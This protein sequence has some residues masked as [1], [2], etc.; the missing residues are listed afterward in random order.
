[1][2][3]GWVRLLKDW[4]PA[5]KPRFSIGKWEWPVYSASKRRQR[6][7]GIME[8]RDA[9]FQEAKRLPRDF[10]Q[11]LSDF[12]SA[13]NAVTEQ[14]WYDFC[15]KWSAKLSRDPDLLSGLVMDCGL[16]GR[17][18]RLKSDEKS[19]HSISYGP[20]EPLDTIIREAAFKLA[21]ENRKWLDSIINAFKDI[22]VK[23]PE[24][25]GPSGE[26]APTPKSGAGPALTGDAKVE[27]LQ[28]IKRF[29]ENKLTEIAE[30]HESVVE[31]GE[32][33]QKDFRSV[34]LTESLPWTFRWNRT[35]DKFRLAVEFLLSVLKVAGRSPEGFEW[36]EL[37]AQA[38]QAIGG[39]KMFDR[40][41]EKLLDLIQEICGMPLED[42]GLTS[43]GSLYPVYILGKIELTFCAESQNRCIGQE[44]DLP[45]ENPSNGQFRTLSL[46]SLHAITNFE[47]EELKSLST[48]AGRIILTENR[49]LLIKMYKTGWFKKSPE[50]F[51]VGIDGRLR[52]SHHR[53][54]KLLQRAAPHIPC[55]IW[56]DS[57][58]PGISF[59]EELH[60][61]FPGARVVFIEGHNLSCLDYEKFTEK[62]KA[63]PDLLNRE[64][65]SLL[66]GPDDWD[67]VFQIY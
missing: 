14:G 25:Y 57:D 23:T 48:P 3:P 8:F 9:S 40:D 29:L 62:I 50:S 43:R 30:L 38:Q 51:V 11:A 20:M 27:A 56:T 58:S 34:R 17:F 63:R 22:E 5:E 41:R 12:F 36:K 60:H 10:L 59:V 66:G 45:Q 39:S 53:I 13:G 26:S 67:R 19:I 47:V 15:K 37:G 42:L 52:L 64:Q 7:A 24:S 1:M 2:F 16:V 6:M 32:P 61:L 46:D 55:Y 21:G 35:N 28:A 4:I 18:I 33:A 49:A 54:L 44:C 31:N 65:E